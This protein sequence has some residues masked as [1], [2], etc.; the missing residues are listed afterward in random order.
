MVA[1]ENRLALA[2]GWRWGCAFKRLI[3]SVWVVMGVVNVLHNNLGTNAT[4]IGM[5]ESTN[6]GVLVGEGILTEK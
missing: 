4:S 6:L 3:A 1:A 5:S 2:D